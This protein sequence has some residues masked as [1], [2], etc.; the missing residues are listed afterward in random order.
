MGFSCHLRNDTEADA[1]Q[2]SPRSPRQVIDGISGTSRTFVLQKRGGTL[3]AGADGKD[4]GLR[5]S[6]RTL[7]L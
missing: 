4:F 1:F 5:S 3:F 2:K 7:V 6:F